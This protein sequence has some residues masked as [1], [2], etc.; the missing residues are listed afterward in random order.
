MVKR[1]GGEFAESPTT[2]FITTAVS[3][4]TASSSSSTN[5][6]PTT[7]PLNTSS[8]TW[9]ETSQSINQLLEHYVG[10]A[11]SDNTSLV[12]ECVS[13]NKDLSNWKGSFLLQTQ[14]I[15]HRIQYRI[16]E[17]HTKCQQEEGSLGERRQ[18]LA[19]LAGEETHLRTKNNLLLKEKEEIKLRIDQYNVEA[20]QEVE[21]ID[22]VEEMKKME[23]PRLQQ[24]ISLY[25]SISGIKWEYDCVDS[26]A[27]EVDIPLKC[28]H[29]RFAID[30]DEHTPFEIA[31]ML[32]GMTEQ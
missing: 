17:C 8:F 20:S 28:L 15:K 2:A 21:K 6:I 26:L 9:E 3:S 7:S 32:W 22:E 5:S 10:S 27:G 13:H 14:D 23:V 31:D 12:K 25:A 11:A 16:D 4:P 30:K 18:H 19:T 24:Q 1:K 29:K